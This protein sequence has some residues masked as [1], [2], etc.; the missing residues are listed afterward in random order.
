[1]FDVRSG[2]YCR[3]MSA[4]QRRLLDKVATPVFDAIAE[5]SPRILDLSKDKARALSVAETTMLFQVGAYR[6]IS[7]FPVNKAI[8]TV[9][10]FDSESGELS[11]LREETSKVPEPELPV[12]VL[13]ATIASIQDQLAAYRASGFP[14]PAHEASAATLGRQLAVLQ[15]RLTTRTRAAAV[16]GTEDAD[17]DYFG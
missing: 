6:A 14:S 13:R 15:Q 5:L 12:W 3:A 4:G 9:K 2:N 7:V 8:W 10:E 17:Y 1:M 11:L 16:V